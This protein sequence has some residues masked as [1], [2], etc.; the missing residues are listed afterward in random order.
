[1]LKFAPQFILKGVMLLLL[2][3]IPAG[4]IQAQNSTPIDTVT[5]AFLPALGYNSDLG[6]MGGGLFNRY[7]YKD[8]VG[9]F[10]SYLSADALASTKG[11]LTAKIF[12]DKPR[13]G[14]SLMRLT[15][16][17]YISRFLQDQYYGIGNYANLKNDME[18]S[19]DSFLF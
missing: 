15:S 1:M 13:V 2:F 16:F 8:N 17:A 11:L 12:Y 3:F 7:H 14:N 19:P 5:H 10:Y 4:H 18:A 6:L 9:P